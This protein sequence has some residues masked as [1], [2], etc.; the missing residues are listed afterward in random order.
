VSYLIAGFVT[1]LATVL[2]FK[3]KFDESEALTVDDDR[4]VA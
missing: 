2:F 1:V 3:S 4:E